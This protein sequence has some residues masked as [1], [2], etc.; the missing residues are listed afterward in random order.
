MHAQ[1]KVKLLLAWCF[2]EG[3]AQ[4]GI[5]PR[6][7]LWTVPRASCA[8]SCVKSPSDSTAGSGDSG[9][10]PPLHLTPRCSSETIILILFSFFL[11][12]DFFFFFLAFTCN[13]IEHIAVQHSL[14]SSLTP[15]VYGQDN[16]QNKLI[17][18]LNR[19][20]CFLPRVQAAVLMMASAS[21]VVWPCD[22]RDHLSLCPSPLSACHMGSLLR[23]VQASPVPH[24]GPQ[25]PSAPF[26]WT[27]DG[28]LPHPFRPQVSPSQQG[29]G[30][31]LRALL[32]D[33]QRPRTCAH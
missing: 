5:V 16:R 10:A 29:S 26:H 32:F 33:T 1:E 15:G 2:F 6:S 31:P 17:L 11:W 13:T 27:P 21:C 28:S 22:L 24:L 12:L 8:C 23:G 19:F 4:S 9:I 14:L 18:C 3:Q 7:C 25:L 20:G 30:W